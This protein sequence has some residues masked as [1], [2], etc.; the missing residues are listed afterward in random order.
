MKKLL[1]ALATSVLI[2]ASSA[3][4]NVKAD[5]P[6]L[7]ATQDCSKATEILQKLIDDGEIDSSL[8]RNGFTDASVIGNPF[9]VEYN[10]LSPQCFYV[11]PIIN[12]S[13]ITGFV[14]LSSPL[15]P[16]HPHFAISGDGF[17]TGNDESWEQLADGNEYIICEDDIGRVFAAADDKKILLSFKY[18]DENDLPEPVPVSAERTVVDITKPAPLNLRSVAL[19]TTEEQEMWNDARENGKVYMTINAEELGAV[20]RNGRLLVPI[21]DISGIMN[22]NVDWTAETKTVAITNDS[23]KV[24]FTIGQPC[25]TLNGELHSID[26]P[27]EIIDG[28]TYIPIRAVNEALGGNI[29][30]NISSKVITMSFA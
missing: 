14:S 30:Y 11:F 29:Y 28:K 7:V 16:N 9:A 19:M 27:A 3:Y 12:D 20:N 22:C 6:I 1:V 25:Y 5:K 15:D 26:V 2:M 18:D 17:F 4:A 13:N 23:N 8:T 24:E 21:R 10:D